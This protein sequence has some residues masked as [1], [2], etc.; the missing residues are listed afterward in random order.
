MQNLNPRRALQEAVRQ[1]QGRAAAQLEHV[2]T[3]FVLGAGGMFSAAGA[4]LL[5]VD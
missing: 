2:R 4:V 5:R 3:S 1:L